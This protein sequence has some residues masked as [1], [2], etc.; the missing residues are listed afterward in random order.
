MQRCN[1]M[2]FT[3]ISTYKFEELIAGFTIHWN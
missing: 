2:M 3:K 1:G